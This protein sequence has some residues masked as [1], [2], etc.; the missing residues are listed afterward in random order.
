M[1]RS[2]ENLNN[3]NN[4]NGKKKNEEPNLKRKRIES[5]ER[6]EEV[7]ALALYRKVKAQLRTDPEKI[8][9]RKVEKKSIKTFWKVLF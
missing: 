3:I 1:K 5:P 9:G 7:D 8:L 4:K 2:R 6:E